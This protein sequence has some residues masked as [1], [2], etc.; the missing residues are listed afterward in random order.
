LSLQF[1]LCKYFITLICYWLF[2]FTASNLYSAAV[3]SLNITIYPMVGVESQIVKWIY[4]PI[5]GRIRA[6]ECSISWCVIG[7]LCCE[8]N[9]SNLIIGSFQGSIQVLKTTQFNLIIIQTKHCYINWTY[10]WLTLSF[11]SNW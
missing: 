10:Y 11:N 5:R 3:L 1:R 2:L 6:V 9:R 7:W 4:Q 8:L